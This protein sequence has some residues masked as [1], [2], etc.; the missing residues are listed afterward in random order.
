M[1]RRNLFLILVFLFKSQLVAQF[2]SAK[3]YVVK[4]N[5][6]SI[7]GKIKFELNDNKLGKRIKL[8]DEQGYQK[9][10]RPNDLK[11]YR[12]T[13]GLYE[14]VSLPN[15]RGIGIGVRDRVFMRRLRNG[16]IKLY[17]YDFNQIGSTMSYLSGRNQ[18]T[19]MPT[20]KETKDLYIESPNS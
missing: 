12:S 7:F 9:T 3:D 2:S 5:G 19:T 14:S 8:V 17:Q 6:D 20:S 16:R 15:T 13:Q 4:V 1:A 10:F 11:A 18:P